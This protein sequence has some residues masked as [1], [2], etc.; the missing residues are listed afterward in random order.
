MQENPKKIIKEFYCCPY[1]DLYDDSSEEDVRIHMES[2][3]YN[4]NLPKRDCTTCKHRYY[5]YENE[6]HGHANGYRPTVRVRKSLCRKGCTCVRSHIGYNA[7]AYYEK[8]E[9]E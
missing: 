8:K 5:Y 9:G 2:C 1:C 6:K 7:C 4:Y 3:S